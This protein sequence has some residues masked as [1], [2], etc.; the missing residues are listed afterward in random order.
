MAHPLA[1]LIATLGLLLGGCVTTPPGPGEWHPLEV[2]RVQLAD[3]ALADAENLADPRVCRYARDDLQRHLVRILPGRLAP[4]GFVG[5]RQEEPG[6]GQTATLKITISRCRIESH[7]WD[8]GGG[9]PDITFYETLGLR[10]WLA[11]ATGEV[12]L[13][14][15]LETVEQIQTDTPTPLFEFPHRIPAT[16]IADHFSGGRI[17]QP[18]G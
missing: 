10:I 18:A 1:L 13:D 11:G 9:E 4:V 2:D 8:V 15:Q 14:R 6:T 12:L 7:Q 3:V 17:W 16:R 5:P